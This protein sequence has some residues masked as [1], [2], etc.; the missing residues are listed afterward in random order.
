M[1]VAGIRTDFR[2]SED[3]IWT[4]S[5]MWVEMEWQGERIISGRENQKQI[6]R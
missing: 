4:T 6:V 3:C 1:E 5:Y 2:C